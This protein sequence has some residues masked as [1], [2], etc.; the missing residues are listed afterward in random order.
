[1]WRDFNNLSTISALPSWNINS[2]KATMQI[3]IIKMLS[4]LNIGLVRFISALTIKKMPINKNKK[5][6]KPII[7]PPMI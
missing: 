4:F 3:P 1:M 7:I 5:Y 2:E 6:Q